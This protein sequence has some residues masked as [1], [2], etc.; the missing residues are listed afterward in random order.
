MTTVTMDSTDSPSF[1]SHSIADTA[2]RVVNE[3]LLIEKN[4]FD[5]DFSFGDDVNTYNNTKSNTEENAN[6]DDE[7]TTTAYN[8]IKSNTQNV[9]EDE[10]E[11]EFPIDEHIS[12]RFPLFDRT[13]LLDHNH[14]IDSKPA[15]APSPT[16][17]RFSLGKLLIEARESGSCSSS[18]ADE[19]D[20][21]TPETYCVWKPNES[22]G[23][24][25]KSNSVSIGN[26]SKRW[27]VRDLL[28]RSYSDD[29]YTTGN[30]VS[31]V[32]VFSPPISPKPKVKG[33]S[34]PEVV[35]KTKTVKKIPAFKGKIG[36]IRLPAYYPYR[37]DQIG[38][39]GNVNGSSKNQYRY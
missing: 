6:E 19:L 4:P 17:V 37:Q 39:F 31:P 16:P 25:K 35:T 3:L 11:F 2:D 36:N 33:D 1:N 14:E 38:V 13:L 23:K 24:H 8:N 20:G 12:P 15:P 18:D 9:K 30:V 26:S 22:R 29:N 7:I 32:I 28:K 34:S 21:I 10:I 27:N 5:N